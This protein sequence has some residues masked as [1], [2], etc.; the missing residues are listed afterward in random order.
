MTIQIET[1]KSG[2]PTAKLQIGE[3][4]LYL[5]SKYDPL[6]EAIRNIGSLEEY[7]LNTVFILFGLGLGYN[8]YALSKYAK[9]NIIVIIEPNE[10]LYLYVK[11]LEHVKPI[12][13]KATVISL[14]GNA[15]FNIYEILKQNTSIENY[16]HFKIY[17]LSYYDK[18]YAEFY[19]QLLGIINKYNLEL[20][21]QVNA[22]EKL[23]SQI[24]TNL[25]ENIPYI[26]EGNSITSFK[27]SFKNCPAIIVSAGPSLEQNIE[28]LKDI[29]DKAVIIAGVRTLKPLLE[30]GIIPHFLCNIDPQ[31][32]TYELAKDYIE[33]SIPFISLVH[34]NHIL[35]EEWRGKKIFIT[36]EKLK[37]LTEYIS[38]EKQD[39]IKV[40]GSV[41]NSSTAIAT[42]MGCNPIILIGQDLAFTNAKHHSDIAAKISEEDHKDSPGDLLVE[43]IH[44][45][46]IPTSSQLY[47]YLNWFENFIRENSTTIFIDATE[48]G[49]KIKGTMI[50]TLEDAIIKYCNKD[51]NAK[52][53]IGHIIE[54]KENTVYNNGIE[55][56]KNVLKEL[57]VVKKCSK[58][59]LE[60]TLELKRYYEGKSRE[61]FKNIL[62]QLDKNDE[63]INKAILANE[64]L[65]YYK[66]SELLQIAQQYEPKIIENDQ[67]SYKRIIEKNESLYKLQYNA[68]VH[69]E[70]ILEEFIEE[71]EIKLF[72]AY[73]T[74]LS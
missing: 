36:D 24:S 59:N 12:L 23:S 7:G 61:K 20:Q 37:K 21:V 66:Q 73:I 74:I 70:K 1:S 46:R 13:E 40:G 54:K 6:K 38:E 9:E 25:I 58:S 65:F 34:G 15:C 19:N 5:H 63:E 51:I 22:I 49:A 29:M 62:H 45:N 67:D 35:V 32:V 42:Y 3:K 71:N 4:E 47:Y 39:I 30:R 44:G 68:A 53:K 10:E 8:L 31:N 52:D 41:A 28:H 57:K 18:I 2:A 64:L 69:F 11:E 27:D 56:L 55:K 26:I 43:D 14:V 72:T 33:L 17:T 60:W 48:G 50:M 16:N